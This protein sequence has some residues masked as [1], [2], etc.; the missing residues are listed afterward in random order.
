MKIATLLLG[1]LLSVY[2]L[3]QS[4]QADSI[5]GY[6][7]VWADEFN[8]GS[9]PHPD[10]WN[11]EI[12]MLRNHELQ[13]Y[14]RENASI[15]RGCL[16]IKAQRVKKENPAF[17][18]GAGDWRRQHRQINYTSSSINTQG[19][20]SWKYGRFVMRAKIDTRKGLWPAFWTLGSARDWPDAGEIDIMEYYSGAILA[21]VATGTGVKYK[22]RWF[23]RKLPL[24][25]LPR[26]FSDNFHVW[27]MD[28]TAEKISLYVD[29]QLLNEVPLS[30]LVLPNGINPFN[31]KHY[32]LLNMAVGGDNGGDPS[33]TAFPGI[34]K[35]DYVRVY[36]RPEDR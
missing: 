9:R 13:W 30:A 7:L 35:I 22:A 17:E 31:E 3:G 5:G 15:E 26:D 36:Q 1:M 28:W 21:N 18:E 8:T 16:V 25:S 33:G 10:N 2:C 11:F 23:S 34:Y 19:H 20:H 32:M 4:I 12:G 6:R 24:D 29:D 14:Q 27:R